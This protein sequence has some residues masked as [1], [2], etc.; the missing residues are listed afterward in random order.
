MRHALTPLV[1]IVLS[2]GCGRD[3]AVAP[4]V[5]QRAAI[6]SRELADASD[7]IEKFL[8]AGRTREAELLARKLRDSVGDED[9]AR[10]RIAEIASRRGTQRWLFRSC[11][12]D[13]CSD[14]QTGRSEGHFFSFFALLISGIATC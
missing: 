2:L 3:A 14:F 10:A 5:P 9:A 1:A 6:S 13:C 8:Q 4:D 11:E 7:A 12:S